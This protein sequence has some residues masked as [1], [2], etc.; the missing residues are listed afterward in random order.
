MNHEYINKSNLID[1]YVLGKLTGAEAEAFELHFI[2][3]SE[4]VDKLNATTAL[5][6]DLKG[7]AV[8]ETLMVG[9]KSV[10]PGWF[11]TFGP[12]S[13]RLWAAV[14]CGCI[15]IAGILGVIANRRLTR[16]EADLHQA[17][18]ENSVIRQQYEQGVQTATQVEKQH[19]ESSQQLTQ[20][21][22]ELE[23]K[24]KDDKSSVPSSE[25]PVVGFPIYSL[26]T[27][28]RTQD[29]PVHKVAPGSSKRF[30]FSIELLEQKKS[31]NY[32]ITIA[33]GRGT[34]VWKG[35]GFRPDE[36]NSLSLSLA[37]NLFK[38]GDYN[39]TVEGFTPPNEW[40][41]VGNFPFHFVR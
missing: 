22:D 9:K 10:S 15:V 8:Q 41:P 11:P 34:T 16:L 37:S 40:S 12:S 26:A 25:G 31:S 17:K 32:R 18:D 36:S 28:V 29:Q 33:D 30:A 39:L 27:V 21:I 23:Q 38:T 35:S 19:Q 2:E 5:V 13:P 20:R 3:C 1:K 6:E 14:A 24:I 4:C 7:L